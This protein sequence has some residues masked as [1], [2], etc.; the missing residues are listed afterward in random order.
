MAEKGLP[1]PTPKPVWAK[2]ATQTKTKE[3]PQ[4]NPPKLNPSNATPLLEPRVVIEPLVPADQPED[5]VPLYPPNQPN[6]LP[7][8]PPD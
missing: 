4:R 5:Q 6:Q 1:A 2:P 7:D 3:R 8:I